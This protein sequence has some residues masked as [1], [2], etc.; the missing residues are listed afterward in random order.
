MSMRKLIVIN[1]LWNALFVA[2]MG[3][4]LLGLTSIHEAL[5]WWGKWTWGI[6]LAGGN[7]VIHVLEWRRCKWIEDN[8]IFVNRAMRP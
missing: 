8:A 1:V 6:A 3:S 2:M 4:E 5:P 7:L